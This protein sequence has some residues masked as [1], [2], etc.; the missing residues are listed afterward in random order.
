[1][2]NKVVELDTKVMIP[3]EPTEE[4]LIA[5]ANVRRNRTGFEEDDTLRPEYKAMIEV[6]LR[7]LK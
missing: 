6:Y 5:G 2:N 3:F 7:N 1:M 4:M